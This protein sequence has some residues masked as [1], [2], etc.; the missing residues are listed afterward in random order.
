MPKKSTNGDFKQ[1]THNLKTNKIEIELRRTKRLLND[2][3]ELGR[4]GGWELDPITKKSFWTEN[5]YRLLGYEPGELKNK[6]K[7]FLEHIVHPDD[8]TKLSKQLK[9]LFLIKKKIATDFRILRKDG[10]ERILHGVAASEFD[11]NDQFRRMYGLNI[12]VTERK[13]ILERTERLNSLN[14]SLFVSGG[15]NYKVKLITEEIIKIFKADF[16]RIWI[17]KPGDLCDSECRHAKITKGPNVCRYRERCLHLL[18]SSGRYTHIDGGHGR[19]PFGSYKIGKVASGDESKFL[20]NDAVNDPLVSDHEWA[21]KLGLVSFAG[22][23][24]LSDDGGVMGVL[25]LFSKQTISPEEDALLENLAAMTTHIIQ[26]AKTE[27][28]LRESEKKYRNIYENAV[29]GFFQSTP[30]GRF[31]SVNFAFANMLG[32]DSPEDLVSSISDI[33]TQYYVNRDDRKLYKK[34]LKDKGIVE[35]FEF[36]AQSKDGSAIWVSNSARAYFGSDGKVIRYEGIVLDINERKQAEKEKDRL[37][38][39]LKDALDKVKTLSGFLP[40]CSHCKNIRDDKGYWSKMESYIHKH[41]EAEFSHA[42]CPECAEK[43]YPDMGL[44]DD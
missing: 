25:A 33:A 44:Y 32:Y 11:K 20:T 43:Y 30:K 37:L 4:V 3:E 7:Y 34:I 15:L 14:E 38:S 26:K 1:K 21:I 40:I 17:I 9:G 10:Q 6:S 12:D 22:Y 23:R 13:Q 36:K 16:A 42:I 29:E 19:V 35:N 5:L 18:A 27:E 2:A 8:R 28:A 39:E 24:L 41:S 31:I